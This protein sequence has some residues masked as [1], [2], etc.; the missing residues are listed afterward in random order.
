[1]QVSEW[2]FRSSPKSERAAWYAVFAAVWAEQFPGEDVPP[3]AA[4]W[5]WTVGVPDFRVVRMWRALDDD[6]RVLGWAE[7]D[8]DTRGEN[9][10]RAEI[11]LGVAA[12]VR[13][14]GIGT[15]LLRPVAEAAQEAGCTVLGFEALDEASAMGFLAR[16]DA[17]S[18]IADTRSV[19]ETRLVDRADIAACAQRPAG[20]SAYSLV[21][22]DGVPSEDQLVKY[23]RVTTAMNTAPIGAMTWNDEAEDPDRLR[24]WGRAIT[25]RGDDLWVVCARHDETG[26]FAGLT[27]VI[28]LSQWPGH[29]WQ[30][31]TAVD[32]AHRGH[33]LGLWMKATMLQRI[34]T[35]RPDIRIIETWNAA[36]NEHMLRVNRRLGFRAVKTGAEIEVDVDLAVQRLAAS[37]SRA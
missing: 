23:A 1:V 9:Q 12:D 33:G 27:E 13:R 26:E 6:G 21:A 14:R 8:R 25:D 20:A 30:E 19:L 17:T 7:L 16:Y 11:E 10:H 2:D 37:P 31:N 29:T 24:A 3:L 15:A 34:L 35:E 36:V 18:C 22:W 32:P 28:H 5:S 4:V